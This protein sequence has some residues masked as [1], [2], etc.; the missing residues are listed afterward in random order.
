[1]H[2]TRE[3]IQSLESGA[4]VSIAVEG[5]PCV[6]IRQDVFDR[7]RNVF[8]APLDADTVYDLMESIMADDDLHDPGLE[9]YQKYK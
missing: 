2:L 4:A 3:Q 7:V 8:E 1:M 6:V 9:S 5:T